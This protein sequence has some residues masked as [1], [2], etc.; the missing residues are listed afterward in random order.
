MISTMNRLLRLPALG[1]IAIMCS[2]G[3]ADDWPQ[4]RGE[5]RD[6]VWNEQG[7]VPELPVAGAD[8]IVDPAWQAEIGAGYSGPTVAKG[9]VYVMDRLKATQTERVLCFDSQTGQSIWEHSY[10]SLYSMGYKAGPRASV[11]VDRGLAFAVGGMGRMHCLDAET[12]DILWQ[13]DLAEDYDIDMP[14]WGI[15]GSPLVYGDLVIQQVAGS[16]GSCMVAFD[17]LKG[18]EVWKAL[19]ERAGYASPIIIQQAGKDVVVCWTGESLSGLDPATGGVFWSHEMPPIKMPIGAATPVYDGERLFVSSFYDGSLMV[20][21]PA[22]KL[23]SQLIWRARGDDEQHT[24]AKSVKTG[25]GTLEGETYGIHSM[26][27]TPIVVGDYIYAVDSY[28]EFRCLEAATGR[29]IWEDKTAVRPGRWSTIHMIRNGE[30]VWMFNERGELMIAKLSPEG[31][32][33][34]ARTKILKPTREQLN[35]RGGVCWSHPAYAEKSIFARSD[36]KLIKIS[37]EAGSE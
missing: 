11:T 7:I 25:S 37:L 4:W 6:G 19:D 17:R 9:R 27:G 2:Q 5:D 26:I 8:G 28:G 22:D 14:A 15:A 29:R 24:G 36:D 33:I 10:V 18:T 12:G 30:N 20:T 3:L 16:D 23:A 34:L 32:N 1:L 31:L 21:A 35:Q 13:R